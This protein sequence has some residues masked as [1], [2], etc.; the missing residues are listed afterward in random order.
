MLQNHFRQSQTVFADLKITLQNESERSAV[1]VKVITSVAL[2]I[3]LLFIN[4]LKIL[5]MIELAH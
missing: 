4:S 2:F 3:Y 1:K 5:K